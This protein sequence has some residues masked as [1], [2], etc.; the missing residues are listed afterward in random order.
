MNV[1]IIVM[2]N[3][4]SQGEY[5]GI[6]VNKLKHSCSHLPAQIICCVIQQRMLLITLD[7][8]DR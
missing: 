7:L 3:I 2:F 5:S 1:V 8:K 4:G 6:C